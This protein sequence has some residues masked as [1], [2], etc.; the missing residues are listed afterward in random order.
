MIWALRANAAAVANV[1]TEFEK[2]N[3]NPNT[4]DATNDDLNNIQIIIIT[5][6]MIYT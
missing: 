5:V 6:V 3:S 2:P 4:F 1:I